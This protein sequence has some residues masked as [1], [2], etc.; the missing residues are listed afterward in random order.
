VGD[1]GNAQPIW[2]KHRHAAQRGILQN[3]WPGS[4]AVWYHERQRKAKE[5]SR[6]KE[7]KET[8]QLTAACNLKGMLNQKK[9]RLKMLLGQ[10]AGAI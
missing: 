3:N 5:Y 6:F 1:P 7:S 2:I 8:R 9:I 4:S 10:P